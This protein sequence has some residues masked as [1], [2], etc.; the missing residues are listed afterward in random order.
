M[1]SRTLRTNS[2][3]F[4]FHYTSRI[5]ADPQFRVGDLRSVSLALLLA[6]V[7]GSIVVSGAA[8]DAIPPVRPAKLVIHAD[9]AGATISKSIYGQFSEHLGRCIYEGI[10]VG[11]K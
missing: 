6:G 3:L 10:W 2:S 7:L 5:L 8:E 4:S 9:Q 11:E 1:P